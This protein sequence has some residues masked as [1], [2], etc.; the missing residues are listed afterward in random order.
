MRRLKG[1]KPSN[2]SIRLGDLSVPVEEPT[3]EPVVES[4]EEPQV[5]EETPVEKPKAKKSKAKKS[6]KDGDIEETV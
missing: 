6:E 5:I 3:A 2:K 1:E 4:V